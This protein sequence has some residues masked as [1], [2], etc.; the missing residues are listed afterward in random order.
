MAVQDLEPMKPAVDALAITTWVGTL[1]GMLPHIASFLTI[2]WM[3][4]RIW[5]SRTANTARV[6]VFKFI[7]GMRERF[8][9]R[10]ADKD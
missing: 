3:T 8:A 1:M 4:I 7:H 2:V 5:E 9:N 10:N 6:K